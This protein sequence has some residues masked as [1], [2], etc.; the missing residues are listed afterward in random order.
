MPTFTHRWLEAI[1]VQK[2]TDF[3]D[4]SEPSLM[5]RVAPS[6]IKS[7]SLTYRRQSDGRRRR[8]ALGRFPT[9]SLADARAKAVR[10]KEAIAEGADPAGVVP[11]VKAPEL[12][13]GTAIEA[14]L[15]RGA[16]RW[17]PATLQ[18]Y[19]WALNIDVIKQLGE[20]PLAE[21]SRKVL[22]ERLEE[23][24]ARKPSAAAKLF[25][26]LGSFLTDCDGRGLLTVTLPKPRVVV[27]AVKPRSRYP[28]DARLVE[29]WQAMEKL[30]PRSRVLARTIILT[31][32]RKSTVERMEWGELDLETALWTI[33]GGRMKAGRDHEVRLSRFA[34]NALT[35][36]RKGSG[37][38]YVF[39]DT[40]EPPDRLNRI[41]KS[42]HGWAGDGWSWH[43]WRRALLTWAVRNGHPREHAK[44]ALA[45][46]VKSDLDRAYDQYDYSA[47]AARVMLAWQSHVERLVGG[48]A[49][50]VVRMQR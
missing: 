36:L 19:R 39:S 32:Q 45:H 47:E 48:S 8:V 34:A 18:D 26:I 10:L 30:S 6:G 3:A 13:V 35:G 16:K 24:S 4:R 40:A 7:W 49:G 44:I 37:G 20:M 1:T 28:D 5:F 27:S 42:L 25:R 22:V 29:I 17:R 43:D 41:L 9:V 33:P 14:W 21:L 2:Q 38:C 23:V 12:T 15:A 46:L 31:A 11:E 50:N